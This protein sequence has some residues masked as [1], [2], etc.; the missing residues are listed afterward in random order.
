MVHLSNPGQQTV[1]QGRVEQISLARGDDET[2]YAVQLR[3]VNLGN[4]HAEPGGST[5]STPRVARSTMSPWR[6]RTE[7][8][9]AQQAQ[10]RW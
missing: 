7:F 10:L 1:A 8:S 4:V 6:G 9:A 5:C 2:S 3:F